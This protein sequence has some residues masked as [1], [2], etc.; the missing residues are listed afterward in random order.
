MPIEAGNSRIQ[1]SAVDALAVGH[2]Q[3]MQRTKPFPGSHPK[4]R[5]CHR[6]LQVGRNECHLAA[7]MPQLSRELF[8]V[9]R[10]ALKAEAASYGRQK[11]KARSQPSARRR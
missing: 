6:V 1:H 4:S 5:G 3:R 2:Y 7:Q 9:L 11:N 10:L 8:R